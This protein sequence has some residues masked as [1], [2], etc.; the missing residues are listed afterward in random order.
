MW[1]IAEPATSLHY[2]A[3]DTD[4]RVMLAL[5]EK[6]LAQTIT[7]GETIRRWPQFHLI[8]RENDRK[9]VLQC[10]A[11]AGA[12]LQLR[13]FVGPINFAF[14]VTVPPESVAQIDACS[15]PEKG[16]VSSRK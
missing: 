15:I 3:Y 13:S 6:G 2:R 14:D 1:M 4:D 5:G 11:D 9:W 10:L 12:P 8:P 16:A 7:L